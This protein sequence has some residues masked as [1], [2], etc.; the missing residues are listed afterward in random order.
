MTQPIVWTVAG[1]DS[2]A[3]AGIQADLKTCEYFNVYCCS[4]L[5]LLTA[6][7]T[8]GVINSLAVD[9]MFLKDQ[10]MACANEFMPSV[11]K[12][13]VIGSKEQVEVIAN[14]L[15]QHPEIYYIC[16]PVIVAT[17]GVQLCDNETLSA[18]KK[19]LLPRANLVTPNIKE[20]SYLLGKNYEP[21]IEVN[22]VK[23]FLNQFGCESVLLKGGDIDSDIAKD[24]WQHQNGE[25]LEL[26]YPKI[27][28]KN[29]PYHGTGCTISSAITAN[30]AKGESIQNALVIAKHYIQNVIMQS[31]L[32][33]DFSQIIKHQI[34]LIDDF[35]LPK[36]ITNTVPV[37]DSKPYKKIEEPMGFYPIVDTSDWVKKLCDWGVKTIQLRIKDQSIENIEQHI[38]DSI[39]IAKQN[40]V[41]LFI[42][43]YWQLAIQHNAY[44]VHLGQE[45]IETADLAAINQAGIHLGISTH[46]YFEL[47]RALQIQ[48]SY[49][50][51]GPI[52]HTTSKQMRFMPQ[53]LEKL[54]LWKKLIG[55]IPLVAIGGIE[56]Q[57]MKF[58]YQAGADGVSVISYVTQSINPKEQVK[59]AICELC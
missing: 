38:K 28:N 55:D 33:G 14:F 48:P 51:L 19:K 30:I 10:V 25:R 2:S 42:N 6:Q 41:K 49:I 7:N 50:A 20:I 15:E 18:I 3:G 26:S 59:K 29:K 16:D 22:L 54:K 58:L 9:E 11:I 32:E 23:Q 34:Q 56:F 31:E 35:T 43:D 39:Q 8:Q 53:G 47:V 24:V 12:T 21:E 17:S 27:Q 40:N 1:S 4:I 46:D 45:D 57:H 37:S 44:G 52:Y 36:L 5:T 13:G